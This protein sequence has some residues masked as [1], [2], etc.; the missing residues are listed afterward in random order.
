LGTETKWITHIPATVAEAKK[1]LN[2]DLIMNPGSDPRYAFFTTD[3]NYGGVPQRAGL[4]FGLK[5]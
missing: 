1:L 3:L 2:S 4:L 5:K